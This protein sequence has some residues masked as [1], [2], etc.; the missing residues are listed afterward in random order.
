M[1]LVGD[2]WL[3]TFCNFFLESND[4]EKLLLVFLAITNVNVWYMTKLTSYKLL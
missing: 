3:L 1:K 2:S 4:L